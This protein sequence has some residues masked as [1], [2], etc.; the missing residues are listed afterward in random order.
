MPS[1]VARVQL[2]C[3][4]IQEYEPRP[5]LGE[6]LYCRRCGTW[7]ECESLSVEWHNRCLIGGCKYSK[8]YGEDKTS[9]VRAAVRHVNKQASHTVKVRYGNDEP[10][11][12]GVAQAAQALISV[13]EL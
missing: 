13:T 8:Y 2:V 11:I 10:I 3:K 12:I 6:V 1:R 4:H 9:A 7:R 5:V